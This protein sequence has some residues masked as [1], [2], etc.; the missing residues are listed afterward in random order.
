[1][2]YLADTVTLVKFLRERRIGAGALRILRE[3]D[4]GQHRI[5][6]SAITL[7]EV[8][9]LSQRRHIDLPLIELVDRIAASPN[10]VTVPI[11]TEI[12]VSAE[13]IDDVPELHDRILAATAKWL[14][15]P[16]LSP[17]SVLMKSKHVQTIWK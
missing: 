4:L 6:V 9:H 11:G 14:G 3:A 8:L 2:E 7:M 12:I 5:H 17:D 13:D 15:V 1:M 16:I 10:Y